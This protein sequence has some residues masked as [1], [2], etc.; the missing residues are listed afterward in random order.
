MNRIDPYLSYYR[1]VMLVGASLL[2]CCFAF[3]HF[4]T[5][6][7]ASIM[8]EDL[9]LSLSEMGTIMGS[10][11]LAYIF[12]SIPAGILLD[13]FGVRLMLL[14][15]ILVVSLSAYLRVTAMDHGDMFIAVM[16]FG[17]GAPFISI[18]TP[19]LIREWFSYEQRGL[20]LG[21]CAAMISLGSVLGLTMTHE[22]LAIFNGSWRSTLNV[23]AIAC[24]VSACVWAL[25]ISHPLCRIEGE[26]KKHERIADLFAGCF[27]LLRTPSIRAM[28][29]LSIGLFFYMHITINWL[30]KL[31]SQFDSEMSVAQ[32]AYWASLPVIVGIVSAAII[33][34]FITNNREIVTLAI[35][36]VMAAISSLLLTTHAATA[37]LIISLLMVGIIR[38]G[39]PLV[40]SLLMMHMPGISQKNTG[41]GMGLFFAFGQIGGVLGPITF[42]Y[43][44]EK[45]GGFDVPLYFLTGFCLILAGVCLK[46]S[47]AKNTEVQQI[48]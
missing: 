14:F 28:L 23:Y 47:G 31:I 25:I 41:A 42:G 46:I 1:W 38:G 20:A 40:S 24:A 32:S 11:P 6:S 4:S 39:L 48:A 8:I 19:T 3:V 12:L 35:L 16:I 34:R 26:S 10:W 30:P 33:P 22:L 15:G 45:S 5:S 9:G 7:L 37:V 27:Q 43:L 17:L 36:L 18:G 2:Y 13:R 29:F 21:I 44:A